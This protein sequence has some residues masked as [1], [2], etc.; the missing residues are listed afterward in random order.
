VYYSYKTRTYLA[1][2]AIKLYDLLID[3]GIDRVEAREAVDE[4][5]T[6]EEAR[7]T[8][9]SREDMERLFRAQ[10]MWIIGLFIGQFMATVGALVAILGQTAPHA[11]I[12]F[13]PTKWRQRRLLRHSVCI[14]QTL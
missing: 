10:T 14:T 8:F 11:V 3:K 6:K 13:T 9:A 7:M 4:I 12:Q 1:P 2:S 5:F